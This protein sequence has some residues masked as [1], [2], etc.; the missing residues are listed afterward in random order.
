MKE[1][2][3]LRIG[4]DVR[5]FQVGDDA[6]DGAVT[7]FAQPRH[8]DARANRALVDKVATRQALVDQDRAARLDL[9]EPAAADE[10]HPQQARK[11]RARSCSPARRAVA[12]FSG[13]GMDSPSYI[14][15]MVES[16]LDV[17]AGSWTPGRVLA[18]SSSAV[19]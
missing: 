3:G 15:S 7:V 12:L 14:T 19:A 11:V 8:A 2:F 18:F 17:M 6:D 5:V 13:G 9:L 16:R 1:Q 10:R 4:V